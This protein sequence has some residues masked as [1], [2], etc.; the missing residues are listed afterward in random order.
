MNLIWNKYLNWKRKTGR[1][2]NELVSK[3]SWLK[4]AKRETISVLAGWGRE[5]KLIKYPLLVVLFAFIFLYNAI[6]Y[7]LIHMKLHEKMARGLAFALTVV[8]TVTNI[9]VSASIVGGTGIEAVDGQPCNHVHDDN[10]YTY[11]T[12]CVHV[13]DENCYENTSVLVCG[14]NEGDGA[15]E[16]DEE[17]GIEA[18][19]GHVHTEECYMEEQTLVCTHE[20][21]EESGCV[22]MVLNC[23]H[24]HD[25]ACGYV[26]AVEGD[27]RENSSEMT[28]GE[29]KEEE[30]EE[31]AEEVV[32]VE[33]AEI[34]E[35]S[36][37][38]A[39]VTKG[40]I[41]ISVSAPAGVFPVGAVL[42]INEIVEQ[43]DVVEIE[44]MVAEAMD[45]DTAINVETVVEES[46]SFDIRI[47]D[48]NG[49]ET[50]PDTSK[51]EVSV[52][53][54]NVKAAE[55]EDDDNKELNVFYVSDEL[56]AVEMIDTELDANEDTATIDAEHFSIYTVVITSG[57]A[58]DSI[59]H[60]Y[61]GTDI[62]N[63]YFTIYNAQQ[64]IT[65]KNLLNNYVAGTVHDTDKI[66]T[67]LVNKDD[68]NPTNGITEL[69]QS[70]DLYIGD[71]NFSVSLM[72]DITVP[73]GWTAIN[74]VPDGVVINGNGHTL[75]FADGSSFAATAP[76]GPLA[77]EVTGSGLIKNIIIKWA[78]NTKEISLEDPDNI[79]ASVVIRIDGQKA[80]IGEAI[81]GAEALAI[82]ADGENYITLERG[83]DLS[84]YRTKLEYLEEGAEYHVYYVY[85]DENETISAAVITTEE[86]TAYLDYVSVTY[87]LEYANTFKDDN[88]RLS[89]NVMAAVRVKNLGSG[90]YEA[91]EDYDAVIKAI[92]G[93]EVPTKAKNVS[94]KVKDNNLTLN[95]DYTY[96]Y[97]AESHQGT[98]HVNKSK[99]NGP[100]VVTVKAD[101]LE[102]SPKVTLTLKTK[103]GVVTDPIWEDKGNSVYELNV[104][105]ST[106]LPQG[107][108]AIN[109]TDCIRFAGWYDNI[110][111]IGNP[112]T[113][114]NYVEGGPNVTYY[115]KWVLNK[116]SDH[117]NTV[118]Y[119]YSTNYGSGRLDVR[120]YPYI[121]T[122]FSDQGF[123]HQT[124][125]GSFMA[126]STVG[127]DI[128]VKL[129]SSDI[130]AALVYKLDGNYVNITYIFEN[131][132]STDYNGSFSL[133]AS[134]DIDINGDDSAVVRIVEDE[135][136]KY[137]TMTSR[138]NKQ[139]KFFLS[140]DSF[141]I[142]PLTTVWYGYWGNHS[143]NVYN[144]N[145]D[146]SF[147]G[148]SGMAF[149][150][151]IS[152]IPA[153][154]YVT[155]STKMGI[156]DAS[157]MSNIQ[158][159]LKAGNGV[160]SDGS[161]EILLSNDN[162]NIVV[163]NDGSVTSKMKN[164]SN[165]TIMP[166][167][168]SGYKFK[169]WSSGAEGGS[170]CKDK[171]FTD[172][173]TL[174]ANW[175]PQPDRKVT[176]NCSV[177]KV[178][179]SN[180]LLV[181]YTLAHIDIENNT[182][183]ATDTFIGQGET[184]VEA[185]GYASGF[186][187][188]LV[189]NGEDDRYLLPDDIEVA[190]VETD[191]NGNTVPGG[192][193]LILTKGTGYDY[194][195]WNNR[196]KATLDIHKQYINGN[197]E[198]TA[199]G[200]ELPPVTATSVTV[201]AAK[202][203]IQYGEK[204]VFTAHADTSKNHVATYNWYVA[205]YYTI[206]LDNVEYW[207]YQNQDGELLSNGTYNGTAL[208]GS[209]IEITGADKATL[210]ISGLDVNAFDTTKAP[211]DAGLH[212]GGY[213]VYCVVRSTRNITGQEVEAVSATT[214]VQV[215]TNTYSA[216]SGLESS[217]TSF[218]GKNDGTI[219][220]ENQDGRPNMKYRL[221][222]T[223]TW[224]DVT[225]SMLNAGK[226]ENLSAGTY[227]FYYPADANH[228]QSV[229]TSVT[230]DNGKYIIVTYR[231]TGC[232]DEN[233]R[234]QQKRVAYNT[235]SVTASTASLVQSDGT[236]KEPAR[237]GYTF[238]GWSPSVLTNVI[239]NQTVNAVYECGQYKINLNSEGAEIAGTAA[240]Y[241]KYSE[242]FFEDE[243]CT[244]KLTGV[245]G[246]TPPSRSGYNFMG[247]YS[248]ADGGT[249]VIN[250][251]GCFTE[252]VINTMYS[253]ETTLYAHWN[254]KPVDIT[255]SSTVYVPDSTAPAKTGVTMDIV[256]TNPEEQNLPKEGYKSD[257]SYDITVIN[258]STQTANVIYIYAD[259][260]LKRTEAN[261]VF[262]G[263][264]YTI[265]LIPADLGGGSIT[266]V[267]AYIANKQNLEDDEITGKAGGLGY[268]IKYMEVG[269]SLTGV[270]F[271]GA[272]TQTAPTTGIKGVATKLPEATKTGY[273][274][275][276]WN[277][278]P[279]GTGIT[280]TEIAATNTAD[281]VTVYANW[282][283]NKY[284]ITLQPN[285]GTFE[286][287]LVLPEQYEHGGK[288]VELPGEDKITRTN[289]TFLGWFDNPECTGDPVTKVDATQVGNVE[290]YAGWELKALHTITLTPDGKD[291][292]VYVIT[293]LEGYDT[294][295]YH[296]DDFKFRV[297]VASAYGVRSVK[298]DGKVITGE[299][300]PLNND[301]D[302]G[303]VDI[304]YV[305]TI[306]NVIDDMTVTVST[307]SL[308]QT[309]P[310]EDAEATILLAD[311]TTG[312]FATVAEAVTYAIRYGNGSVI[313]LM[314]DVDV[315]DSDEIEAGAGNAFTIDI[316]G[317]D[318]S[319]G[320]NIV[321]DD[322]ADVTLLDS[323]GNGQF[324][325]AVENNGK[326]TNM[327]DITEIKNYGVTNNYGSVTT[328]QQSGD[329]EGK[330]RFYNYGTVDTALIQSGYYIEETGDGTA[331]AGVSGYTAIMN[332]NEYYYSFQ[333]A[334]DIANESDTDSSILMLNYVDNVGKT[335]NIG[336][337][338]ANITVDTNGHA[339]HSGTINMNGNVEFTNS[340]GSNANVIE[341]SS[342]INNNGAL[343][344][345]SYIKVSGTVANNGEIDVANNGTISGTVNNAENATLT[346][347][348]AVTGIVNNSGMVTN[349]GNM[350]NVIQTGGH[351][352]NYGNIATKMQINGGSYTPF[353]DV[354]AA[355]A[356]PIG[357]VIRVGEAYPYT[358]YATLKEAF[359]DAAK[360]NAQSPFKIT[361]LEDIDESGELGQKPVVL[362]PTVPVVIELDGHEIEQGPIVIGNGDGGESKPVVVQDSRSPS[363]GGVK[364][365][366]DVCG[367]GVLKVDSPVH[368]NKVDNEGTF[369]N[370]GEV[371]EL[372]NEGTATNNGSIEQVNQKSGEFNNEENGEV[373]G[374]TQT[375]GQT[376][377][378]GDIDTDRAN[379]TGGGF[380][381]N[382][383]EDVGGKQLYVKVPQG[384]GY[385]T[386]YFGDLD[387][388]LE[389]VANNTTLDN[390]VYLM[391][392]LSNQTVDFTS[393][394]NDVKL[395]LNGHSIDN[396]STITVGENASLEI[397]NSGSE[398]TV[399]ADVVNKGQLELDDVTVNGD[400]TNKG[401]GTLHNNGTVNGVTTN[402]GTFVN[403]GTLGETKQ[404]GG[405]F[406]NEAGA[407]TGAF[408]QNGGHTDNNGSMDSVSQ[409]KGSYASVSDTATPQTP[410]GAGVK[411]SDTYYA[412]L[413]EAIEAAN[414][415]N[416]D[417]TI[418]LI[419]DVNLPE[420]PAT[421]IE[422][423]NGKNI[424]IDLNG[425]DV[426]GGTLQ[427][428][429]GQGD[430]KSEVIVKN[431]G[432]PKGEV[433]S[434]VVVSGDGDLD[435]N[436]E[437]T[438]SGDVTNNGVTQNNGNIT[439][440]VEN[441]G[442]FEN[443]GSLGNVTQKGGNLNNT[444]DGSITNLEQQ[445]GNTDN[446]GAIDKSEISG[447]VFTGNPADDENRTAKV[448]VKGSD[449]VVRYY[450]SIQD[451]IAGVQAGEEIV[452]L[453]D[454]ISSG[455]IVIDKPGVTID[456]NGHSI[457]A[458]A[459]IS[460]EGGANPTSIKNSKSDGEITAP[461]TNNGGLVLEVK[462]T[463]VT[464][465]GELTNNGEISNLTNNGDVNN[466]GSVGELVQ[467]KGNFDNNGEVEKASLAG[468]S[469][470]G[471]APEEPI[472]GAKVSVGDKYF[473]DLD[474]AIEEANESNEDVTITLLDDTALPGS[475]V[476]EIGNENGKEITL[477]L[478]GHN[479]SGGS[480]E[481]IA[482]G[483]TEIVNSDS[484]GGTIESDIIVDS[485]AETHIDDKITVDGDVNNNG[486]L[487]NSGYV[488][489]DVTNGQGATMN[490]EGNID[491]HVDNAGTMEN[492][493]EI[494]G[495][496]DNDGSFSNVG[497]LA[498]VTGDVN[499]TGNLSNDD[500]A[501]IR[502]DV[503]N[504]GNMENDGAV[505]GDVDNK[506]DGT[507]DNNGPITGQ[508]VNEDN[509]TVNNSGVINQVKQTG[510][511]IN[512]EDGGTL[513][514]VTQTGG[515][516]NN[517]EG[518]KL[519][520]ITQADGTV[521]NDGVIEKVDNISDIKNF[522]GN[523]PNGGLP[524]AEASVT[525]KDEDGKDV[526]KYYP[527]LED[528]LDDVALEEGETAK[529]TLTGTP[530][531]IG[532]DVT[533][534]EGVELDIPQGTTLI[535]PDGKTLTNE[536]TVT[537]EG[538]LN[539]GGTII[540][541]EDATIDNKGK[542]NND[543][544]LENAEN[545]DIKN[546]GDID[547]SGEINN[548]GSVKNSGD[549]SN[550]ENGITTNK[551]T[552]KLDNNGGTL[553][554]DDDSTGKTVNEGTIS[555]GSVSGPFE[556]K[557]GASLDKPDKISG[558]ITN[559]GSI[560]VSPRTDTKDAN[561]EGDGSLVLIPDPVPAPPQDPYVPY[562]EE[563]EEDYAPATSVKKDEETVA[564]AVEET[565][566]RTNVSTVSENTEGEEEDRGEDILAK[567][568]ISQ[569][570]AVELLASENEE[571]VAKVI[572][573]LDEA[574]S[575]GN[576]IVNS[577][578]EGESVTESSAVI[579]SDNIA[580]VLDNALTEEEK[581]AVLQGEKVSLR[582]DV[583][584]TEEKD[585]DGGVKAL[586][587]KDI[588][589]ESRIETYF[590]L[591][592]YKKVG[593]ARETSATGSTMTVTFPIPDIYE[594]TETEF[595]VMRVY[596]DDSGKLCSEMV[597]IQR[598][599]DLITM[600]MDSTSQYVLLS[601]NKNAEVQTISKEKTEQTPPV[602]ENE[603]PWWI[604]V[605]GGILCAG[606]IYF[607]LRKSDK[608][609]E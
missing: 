403:D 366:I 274:F 386:V 338:K 344:L 273:T 317:H 251:D 573:L 231:A 136:C 290:Y 476:T 400:V 249:K 408:T 37:F 25:D 57:A 348:G 429:D 596:T 602:N 435:I 288:D 8:M 385:K 130:Y 453:Q 292:K 196:K 163:N 590:N 63:S 380:D 486:T 263:N 333:D 542:L 412:S 65:Y 233:L 304:G 20:C 379:V 211:N 376:N 500:D 82:S 336:N 286:T 360:P 154:G 457:N 529:I 603:F 173:I 48:E 505:M 94:I 455:D 294:D 54:K 547:N 260:V 38:D 28:S 398:G 478:N 489:G 456:L 568:D 507:L 220:I 346:N 102:D 118:E 517:E 30:A 595:T 126:Q 18:V 89:K 138:S 300:D 327:A 184:G 109:N 485:G 214:E 47:L 508:V 355:P 504:T 104:Y 66:A 546:S 374:L 50:E 32:A 135:N 127:N 406:T 497:E 320:M 178:N 341:I 361:L 555:G 463:D 335:I 15:I 55:V 262:T 14:M 194:T 527:T 113:T 511:S 39:V 244:K 424:T 351:T 153:G 460:V 192:Q 256:P 509:A 449:G 606:L 90:N 358:Y 391:Q 390:T 134:T 604:F 204:A 332:G 311:G 540:N 322:G 81:T 501:V 110:N 471:D 17:A 117:N 212:K 314:K 132:G 279:R 443:N 123:A 442:N 140:G 487:D 166:P 209:N 213:H 510:G 156:G 31:E 51:G 375:G 316:N 108:A 157:T 440:D 230:V 264:K 128:F 534:P 114:Y 228:N 350:N 441:S 226:I 99:I 313:K 466:N 605:A 215:T 462:A 407:S 250:E 259:G 187:G 68:A 210:R 367:D 205:P 548:E 299:E 309:N 16:A 416:E 418:E 356:V 191:A 3:A 340:K 393:D 461:I 26:E 533:I 222:T 76:Y 395:D 177:Q 523:K 490:N 465:D 131:R 359:E 565:T 52:T 363:G 448:S 121:Q 432:N 383:A 84:S 446:D 553:N 75:S 594:G 12:N 119:R 148:D 579:A 266:I 526:T 554:G 513:N 112:I 535:I 103:G 268:T 483:K 467:N 239:A 564:E 33:T 176:N 105:E 469:F 158:A 506:G 282:F 295:V 402:E 518:G 544:Q 277:T 530:V 95:T 608:K 180:N 188:T 195:L 221:G 450:D 556:N 287:G 549:I 397:C 436:N 201:S 255:V 116:S 498:T 423:E 607:A 593:L 576:V 98:I 280:I 120:G 382:G 531:T 561:V 365:E 281:E 525:F 378:N 425:H 276:G 270:E 560:K 586:V 315:L 237:A 247:Y 581:L 35:E 444:S 203:T 473:G 258:G 396:T 362:D 557:E 272:F 162:K 165:N 59:L 329:Y 236:I 129:G 343:S 578:S 298:V 494:G 474:S 468:G 1:R 347:A 305:Y 372:E 357:T 183:G 451:A 170:D 101:S 567:N 235:A 21:T 293:P 600:V 550:K 499:N 133:G 524:G 289:Y 271:T 334:V 502:G 426:T 597:E 582:I 364:T 70:D 22:Q 445:G 454:D 234:T 543:G 428:G 330:T 421:V 427:I 575:S 516:I 587:E 11:E 193:R 155:K 10:C 80:E 480:I 318:A 91:L 141:G 558:E 56:D 72:D 339:I 342:A 493:G 569:E 588:P 353:T 2:Y 296:N 29:E 269:S 562:V 306:P 417:T 61:Q 243:D 229:Q 381:G 503:T 164:G 284:N 538:S 291:G 190:I 206:T 185:A 438:V 323:A 496:L 150:W 328:V 541:E 368:V 571:D 41:E 297:A 405:T 198:I 574:V 23:N 62:S 69:G 96:A 572:A 475:F 78:G 174:V 303:P 43:S 4:D 217:A 308:A 420:T 46:H 345:D 186:T 434:D 197:I 589:A 492:T 139:F 208:Q 71:L 482:P 577:S 73:S 42:D 302:N 370:D 539:N 207:T 111:C 19:P 337:S 169:Y 219:L 167:T 152:N 261:A 241:E 44:H 7:L 349:N 100:M 58:T 519:N 106:V 522:T 92:D 459:T 484:T 392:D 216:P 232:D 437:V 331:P 88:G 312:Y 352:D 410:D 598:E 142:D 199:A 9:Y 34:I 189:V 319:S 149:S 27:P 495:G 413:E 248:E 452:V 85:E 179:G 532:E 566:V 551:E 240:I 144:N 310:N 168:R 147:S 124:T 238:K 97:D 399:E 521:E 13:H 182:E 488:T 414:E 45:E 275:G 242:G 389:Y 36:E 267:A 472:E 479:I 285:N 537:N 252:N 86:P 520:Q 283:A 301:D 125:L 40:D 77:V 227:Y 202:D 491:G 599:G 321:I 570:E 528:A 401:T 325:I 354:G 439:G 464:N 563:E 384:E 419:A 278:K 87:N 200:Y 307:Q 369:T 580:Q 115:A 433:K 326:F 79:Y 245:K 53:F 387:S 161:T 536:G 477:D 583:V 225:Q 83:D 64:L 151:S 481:V 409:N 145:P 60:Y 601:Q 512:N 404:N 394:G 93:H 377:N 218:Y 6:F 254:G 592:L 224:L 171:T 181:P 415:L 470:G 143:S 584:N 159:T 609:K 49:E 265:S 552:G 257:V 585:I 74:T 431:S 430:D 223:G 422:N 246:I 514:Q 411:I 24:V 137:V 591:N 458:P 559:D 324:M 253:D 388:A 146:W 122:T 373:G 172:N 67:I 5:H 175:I 107:I 160:F 515:N 371:D 545:A 447:G